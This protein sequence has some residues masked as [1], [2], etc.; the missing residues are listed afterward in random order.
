MEVSSTTQTTT[1]KIYSLTKMGICI[2]LLAVASYIYIPIPFSPTGITAQTIIVNLIALILT[3]KQAFATM[4]T[5]LVMGLIG[6]P[7]FSGGAT[8]F[9]KLFSPTGGF[10]F[11]FLAA[12]VVISM[13]N[14]LHITK[15]G[16]KKNDIRRYF[17]LTTVVGMPIIYLFGTAFMCFFARMAV[18]AALMAAVVPYLLGDVLKTAVA[19]TLAIAINKTRVFG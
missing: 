17:L 10:Y 8:G 16:G 14:K 12:V 2:A 7:V 6:L 1:S 3:P 9:A 11:G 13:L 19:C 15:F 18:P 4:G 5:Y